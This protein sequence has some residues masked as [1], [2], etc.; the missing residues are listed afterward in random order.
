[1]SRVIAEESRVINARAEDIYAVMRDYRAGHPAVLPKQYFKALEIEQGGVGE[2]TIIRVDMDVMGVK[3]SFRMLVSEPEPG[4]LLV[5]RNLDGTGETQFVF[6]PL[7][8]GAKTRVTIKSDFAAAPGFR[9]FMERLMNPMIS[10]RI[11][12]EELAILDGYMQQKG[13]A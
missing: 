2:G 12:R 1:M 7:E 8:G 3:R 6:Q 13:S 4:R 10:R 9:G 5:E 11:Y